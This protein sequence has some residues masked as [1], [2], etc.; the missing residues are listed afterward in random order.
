[1]VL[2]PLTETADEA[3]AAKARALIGSLE[4]RGRV[5]VALSGGIDSALLLA[6]AREAC[7]R[8]LA[9]TA[10]SPIHPRRETDEARGIARTVGC[11]HMILRTRELDNPDFTRNPLDRCYHCKRSLFAELKN[12][13]AR[14]GLAAVVE[15]SNVEDLSDFRPGEKAL[16]ELGIESPLRQADLRKSEIRTLAR[17]I[18]LP[19]AERAASA[20]LATRFPY[21]TEI[22]AD[23]L[24]RVERLEDLLIRKGFGQVRARYYIDMVR[25]EVESDAVERFFDAGL[26]DGVIQAAR[27]EGFRH[28]ALDLR[29][30]RQGSLNP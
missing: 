19:N 4:E 3:V 14:E 16:R 7:D 23:A 11:E 8:V 29:G 27:R 10:S 13:A 2:R 12:V 24:G 1:M 25:I 20:C 21:G 30:Y 28:V 22:T 15:G 5:L 17:W 26:R 18:G 6:A 9:V